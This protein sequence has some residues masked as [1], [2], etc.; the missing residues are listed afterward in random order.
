M[1]KAII[2]DLDDTLYNEV[3]FVKS[4]YKVISKKIS[5]DYNIKESLIYEKLITLFNKSSKNVFNRLLD[6][7]SIKYDTNYINELITLYR[8]HYPNIKLTNEVIEILTNLKSKGYVL[9]IIS[10][11]NYIT[12]KNKCDALKLNKYF[13]EIILTDKYGKE[14]WKPNPYTF[15]LFIKKFKLYEENII[16]IGDNPKKDFYIKQYLNIKTTRLYN[17]KG[18]YY[19]E[20]YLEGIKEDYKI[21]KISEIKNIIK[22]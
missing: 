7:L 14:Y 4:G 18:V 3:D 17:P 6:D 12:Q 21:T 19:K 8:E 9:G 10:D 22:Y 13:D 15:K 20:E 1:I 2:F 5:K 11:G 16:Y